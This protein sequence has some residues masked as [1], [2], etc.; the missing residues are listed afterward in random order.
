[1]YAV[2]YRIKRQDDNQVLVQGIVRNSVDTIFPAPEI[3]KLTEFPELPFQCELHKF[4]VKGLVLETI[5][6]ELTWE[7]VLNK[8]IT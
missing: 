5:E 1:M 3:N 6:F 8:K 4:K 2:A 7:E